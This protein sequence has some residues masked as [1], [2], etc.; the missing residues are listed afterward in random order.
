MN[1]V[2]RLSAAGAALLALGLAAEAQSPPAAGA[3][4]MTFFVTSVGTGQGAD[5]GGLAGAD[6]HCQSLAQAAGAGQRSWRAYLSTSAAAGQPAINARDRIG[7]GPWQ[8]AL[9]VVVA[10]DVEQLHSDANNLTKQTSVDERGRVVS[11]RGDPV[12]THDVLT[13]SQEDGRAYP[14]NPDMTCRNWTYSG[15]EGAAMVGHHDRI[16]LRDDAPSKS[17]NTSHPS[18]GC[19][20]EALR[21][22][23]GAGL[24][25]CFATN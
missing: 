2:L 15:A 1:R 17:W 19:G 6:A 11:G 16:G 12:N 8:N 18:R 14:G 24:F 9:G 23:G 20:Q 4:G 3:A 25:Y 10:R 5:L 22:S 13:G 21:S 7:S